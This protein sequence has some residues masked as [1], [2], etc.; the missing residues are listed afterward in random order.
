MEHD[1]VRI[2]H[3]SDKMTA[4]ACLSLL[5]VLAPAGGG[6]DR[7]VGYFHSENCGGDRECANPGADASHEETGEGLRIVTA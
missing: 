5:G 7:E 3:L 4:A 6:P 2:P 1:A